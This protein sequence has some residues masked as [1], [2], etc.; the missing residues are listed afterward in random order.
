MVSLKQQYDGQDFQGWKSDVTQQEK[1]DHENKVNMRNNIAKEERR[2][3]VQ[4]CDDMAHSL[5]ILHTIETAQQDNT[6]K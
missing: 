4:G 3:R 6:C 5:S 2:N 1:R